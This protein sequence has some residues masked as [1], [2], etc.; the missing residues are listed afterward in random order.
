MDREEELLGI[1]E[2]LARDAVEGLPVHIFTYGGGSTIAISRSKNQDNI[3]DILVDIA[4]LDSSPSVTLF[5]GMDHIDDILRDFPLN[6]GD[7][8][9]S[10][11]I[12]AHV[13]KYL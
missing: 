9:L 1:I 5:K 3:S 10:A 2:M 7:P 13:E 4:P 6:L 12:R 11:T 8:G